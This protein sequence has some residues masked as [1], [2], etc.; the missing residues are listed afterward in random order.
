MQSAD[1]EERRQRPALATACRSGGAARRLLKL[2]WTLRGC[3]DQLGIAECVYK[4]AAAVDQSGPASTSFIARDRRQPLRFALGIMDKPRRHLQDGAQTFRAGGTSVLGA[5]LK[6][7][8][9]WLQ[10]MVTYA[11]TH[12]PRNVQFY[13]ID[14]GGGGLIDLETFH[15]GG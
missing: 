4:M 10:T 3:V 9:R 14:L 1:E 5:H 13:C 11:A 15:V 6:P 2:A 7:G 8:S 12:S